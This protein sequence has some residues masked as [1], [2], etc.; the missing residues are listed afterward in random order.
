[1]EG[2]ESSLG[3]RGRAFWDSAQD[4]F[5]FDIHEAEVLLEACRGMDMIDSLAAAVAADGV[6]TRGSQG[7]PVLNAAVGELRQQQASV[8]RLLSQLN[9]DAAEVGQVL[10][11]KQAQARAA[12]QARWREKKRSSNG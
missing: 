11:A 12:A 4:E 2:S 3:A 5:E 10:S 1:M 9:L 7:Q 6:M 8:A